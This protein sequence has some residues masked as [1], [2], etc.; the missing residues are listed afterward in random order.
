[1]TIIR[2]ESVDKRFIVEINRSILA[3]IAI[4]CKKAKEVETGGVLVGRY[5]ENFHVAVVTE[6][7]PPPN[8]SKSSPTKFKRG[9]SGL[10][11][12]FLQRWRATQRTYYIGEWHYH[13]SNF[14]EPSLVD[15][16]QMI[17]FSY[18]EDYDCVAPIMLLAGTG[19]GINRPYR[20]FVFPRSNQFVELF[21]QGNTY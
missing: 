13:P 15:F 2:W 20:V 16:D 10:Q 3:V 7:P 19:K 1:M 5:I 17:E 11:Q 9:V 18:S 8:D 4:H 14:V 12:L 6:A 21:L